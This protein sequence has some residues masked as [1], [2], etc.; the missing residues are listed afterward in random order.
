MAKLALVK[1]KYC[2]ISFSREKE[3]F[4]QEG[5]RYSHKKCYEN[6]LANQTQEEKDKDNFYRY[7]KQ[8]FGQYNYLVVSR[9]AEKYIQEN[10][11]TYSGM[12]KTLYYFYEIKRNP[13]EKAKG[14]IAIIPYVY[15][16]AKQYF[17]NIAKAQQAN[18]GKQV[19]RNMNPVK[20]V[21]ITSP[22]PEKKKKHKLFK[23][24]DKGEE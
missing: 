3:E 11:Y 13:I 19:S 8:L 4:V 2:N 9:M 23:F 10:G 15:E 6:H 21:H 16:E 5:R 20:V 24:L 7:V 17:M 14:N 18:A 12:T 1:C 22:Q